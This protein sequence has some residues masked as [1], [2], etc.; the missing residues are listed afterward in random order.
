MIAGAY[1]DATM[2]RTDED[3]AAYLGGLPDDI[4]DDMT[5]LD[6]VIRSGMGNADRV[7][8]RGTFWGGSQQEIIGYG[9]Y[10]SRRSDGTDVEWFVVGLARQKAYY[11]VYVSAVENGDYL[12][13]TMGPDLGKVDVG[14][15]KIG[16][17]K[18]EDIDLDRLER[19]VVRARELSADLL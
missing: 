16:F 4:R 3:V 14:A 11:S 1:A 9:T 13:R 19:L 5:T 7:L 2:D 18:L 6:R 17:R 10:S 15:S 12:S 8:Y